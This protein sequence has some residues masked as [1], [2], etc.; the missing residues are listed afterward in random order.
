MPPDEK[1]TLYSVKKVTPPPK[2]PDP[3]KPEP[4]KISALNV[5]LFIATV[6]QAIVIATFSFGGAEP[7]GAEPFAQTRIDELIEVQDEVIRT[8]RI[9]VERL[10]NRRPR[11]PGAPCAG[12]ANE[13]LDQL[14]AQ[15]EGRLSDFVTGE[16]KRLASND[17]GEARRLVGSDLKWTSSC[18]QPERCA[19]F[20]RTNY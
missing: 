18:L 11:R 20:C 16:M 2:P 10:K 4:P 19:E 7:G 13:A 9:E 5:L 3:P 1:E 12:A 17:V 14:V 8:L 15:V 6:F